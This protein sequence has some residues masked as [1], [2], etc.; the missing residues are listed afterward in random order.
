M[1]YLLAAVHDLH[2]DFGA[3]R[4]PGADGEPLGQ[5]AVCLRHLHPHAR[6]QLLAVRRHGLVPVV[7]ADQG[8]TKRRAS[9]KGSQDKIRQ[10]KA[11]ISK[12]QANAGR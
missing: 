4:L 12:G 6:R 8:L 11:R 1:P 7:V 5:R 10:D 2:A 3:L 9:G